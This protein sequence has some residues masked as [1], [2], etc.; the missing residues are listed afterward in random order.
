MV[1]NQ[2]NRRRFSGLDN[3]ISQPSKLK[4]VLAY[5]ARKWI[6]YFSQSTESMFKNFYIGM[7]FY[8]ICQ[9]FQSFV[10]QSFLSGYS[11]YQALNLCPH[12]RRRLKTNLIFLQSVRTI[13]ILTISSSVSS[14]DINV[15]VSWFWTIAELPEN[16]S[17]RQNKVLWTFT[18]VDELESE[19]SGSA[20]FRE[21]V[22]FGKV[23][24]L[25]GWIP[26][27]F[28][29]SIPGNEAWIWIAQIV[30][31]EESFKMIPNSNLFRGNSTLKNH[32]LTFAW[33]FE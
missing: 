13:H 24:A 25:I 6:S 10:V 26:G 16:I 33:A 12:D 2:S 32:F 31:L 4:L 14:N 19:N 22:R 15:G 21:R 11:E 5:L 1:E 30:E 17:A 3:A 27:F 7:I 8:Q 29:I 28:A 9:N 20:M 18:R 23:W